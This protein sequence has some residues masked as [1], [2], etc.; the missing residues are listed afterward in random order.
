[1]KTRST[2]HAAFIGLAF[3][4]LSLTASAQTGNPV[5]SG[6][7]NMV[8]KA[9]ETASTQWISTAQN[10]AQTLFGLLALIDFAWTAAILALEGHD[11]NTYMARI[12]RKLMTISVFALLLSQG[13]YWIG[14][15]IGSFVKLGQQTAQ[16]AGSS[17]ITPGQIMADGFDLAGKTLYWCVAGASTISIT[18]MAPF[19]PVLFGLF[20]ALFILIAYGIVVINFIVTS[21]EAL[22]VVGAGYIFLGFGGSQWTRSYTERYI[23]LAVSVGA[24]LMVLYMIVGLGHTFYQSWVPILQQ[25]DTT[26][27]ITTTGDPTTALEQLFGIFAGVCTYVGVA[28]MAPRLVGSIMS[29]SLSLSGNEVLGGAAGAATG[30]AALGAAA[31]MAA[32]TG[33]ASVAAAGAGVGTMAAGGGAAGAGAAGSAAA[34]GASTAMAMSPQVAAP[35]ASGAGAAGAGGSSTAAGGGSAVPPPPMPGGSPGGGATSGSGA[36][37]SVPPPSGSGGSGSDIAGALSKAK[38]GVQDLTGVVNS[39]PVEA[40]PPHFNV[41]GEGE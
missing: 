22:V 4:L 28:L 40:P 5:D 15:I 8:F 16:A 34:G 31:V 29:G 30:V 7:P 3:L 27:A 35:V 36:G 18:A 2:K 38:G 24:R 14:A 32:P 37:A 41:H 11:L 20:I 12:I 6:Q 23:A 33:G 1:M 10:A 17:A 26:G 13:Q 25:V 39:G 19:F 21:I 9:Y